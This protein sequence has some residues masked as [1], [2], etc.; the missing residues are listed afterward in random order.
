[1][2]LVLSVDLMALVKNVAMYRTNTGPISGAHDI[3][4]TLVAR[5]ASCTPVGV[6][7]T[8]GERTVDGSGFDRWEQVLHRTSDTM[9]RP[10]SIK[11][12]TG[13][14]PHTADALRPMDY[15]TYIS[16]RG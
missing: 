12:R 5:A 14:E 1:M 2:A 10:G 9:Y 16:I 4:K 11:D 13:I 6:A 8:A 3:K 15:G 7:G